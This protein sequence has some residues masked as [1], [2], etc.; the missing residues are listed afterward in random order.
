LV[1]P[2]KF[3]TKRTIFFMKNI[4]KCY[5]LGMFLFGQNFDVAK[6]AMIHMK[7]INQNWLQAKYNIFLYFWLHT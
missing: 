4:P 7:K 1:V 5:I 3:A 2:P 6:V